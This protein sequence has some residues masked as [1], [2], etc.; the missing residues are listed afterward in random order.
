MSPHAEPNAS[1]R[2]VRIPPIVQGQHRYAAERLGIHRQLT[3]TEASSEER[4]M[5][6]LFGA[7][8]ISYWEL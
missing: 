6:F 4:T 2:D 1:K 3:C 5:Y 7:D 8:L